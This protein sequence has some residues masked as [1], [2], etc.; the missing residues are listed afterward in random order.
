MTDSTA[1]KIF[2]GEIPGPDPNCKKCEG[3]GH[4]NYDHNHGK[5]CEVCC[6]HDEGFWLLTEHHQNAGMMCCLRGCG[7]VKEK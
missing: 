1:N 2:R 6:P 4:Y 5:I 3:K 7:F